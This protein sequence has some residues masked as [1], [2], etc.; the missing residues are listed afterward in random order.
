MSKG[1]KKGVKGRSHFRF[2]RNETKKIYGT[3]LNLLVSYVDASHQRYLQLETEKKAQKD[4]KK[5]WGMK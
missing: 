2:E 1:G 3:E 5:I 4:V